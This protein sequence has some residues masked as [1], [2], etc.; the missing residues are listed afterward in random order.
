MKNRA[1]INGLR[2]VAVLPIVIFHLRTSIFTG[3]FVGVDI[4][5]VI[6]GFLI[7]GGIFE[8]IAQERFS[9]IRFYERRF[10]RIL[11]ALIVMLLGVTIAAL[12]ILY[13]PALAEY[14]TSMV[15]AILSVSNFHFWQVIDYFRPRGL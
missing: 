3:G 5:Y 4:F 8:Q 11:P 7:G 10:R 15:A 6:S 12:F 9:I 1:D 14:A 2:A 13:P